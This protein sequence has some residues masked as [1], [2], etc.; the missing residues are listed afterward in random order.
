MKNNNIGI[1]SA[2][3]I[4]LRY[5]RLLKKNFNF[6]NI[7]LLRRKNIKNKKKGVIEVYSLKEFLKFNL[8]A[9]VICSPASMH[10]KDAFFFIKNKIPVFVEKPISNNL[11]GISKLLNIKKKNKT[12]L[13]VG[14]VLKHKVDIKIL[15]QI[16]SKLRVSSVQINCL[17]N[18]KKWRKKINYKKTSSASSKLGGGVLFELSHEIDYARY[19]FGEIKKVFCKII[20]SKKLNIN[21]EDEVHMIL[22]TKSNVVINIFLSFSSDTNERMCKINS[23]KNFITWNVSES[24]IKINNKKFYG[25]KIDFDENYI[26]QFKHFFSNIYNIKEDSHT[27]NNAIQTLKVIM[28]CKLSNKLKKE[29]TI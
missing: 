14:Y 8:S 29:I 3:S 26:N 7:V 17:S 21:V 22:T 25:K 10:V 19:L 27:L 18:L 23:N 15:K 13:Q 2:G 24:E 1:V 12:R 5:I 11:N 16:L 20:F 6:K 4:G 9:V 28:A